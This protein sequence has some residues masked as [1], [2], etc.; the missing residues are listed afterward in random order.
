MSNQ[1]PGIVG[2]RVAKPL[3]NGQMPPTEVPDGPYGHNH[4]TRKVI[5]VT[6]ERALVT[7]DDAGLVEHWPHSWSFFVHPKDAGNRPWRDILGI[8][9]P[10]LDLSPR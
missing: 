1:I 3:A 6:P 4:W 5:H 2:C 7:V 10:P 9:L 8:P